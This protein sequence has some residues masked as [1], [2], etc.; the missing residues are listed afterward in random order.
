MTPERPPGLRAQRWTIGALVL[1]AIPMLVV[2]I[3][4]PVSRLF[5]DGDAKPQAP[6][7]AEERDLER[8]EREPRPDSGLATGL[9]VALVVPV[10]ACIVVP[11]VLAW[12]RRGR[13]GT[14]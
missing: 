4:V 3:G 13:D 5:D 8:H 11:I 2:A 1:I 14:A 12:R 10:A 7:T 6:Q 9:L